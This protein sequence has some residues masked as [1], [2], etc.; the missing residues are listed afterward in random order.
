MRIPRGEFTAEPAPV[1]PVV[2]ALDP[3]GTLP[4][5]ALA[6]VVVPEETARWIR[7]RVLPR[8]AL[9]HQGPH[10]APVWGPECSRCPEA[11]CDACRLGYDG[12]CDGW[13]WPWYPEADILSP[14]G[15]QVP[16]DRP[17]ELLRAD[18][19]RVWLRRP[20]ECGCDP[21]AVRAARAAAVEGEGERRRLVEAPLPGGVAEEW[22]EQGELF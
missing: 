12:Q 4:L 17:W 19:R 2:A 22:G 5:P 18:A 13:S 20:C 15:E 7:D 1:V 14:S 9:R 8:G 11:V 21:V 16:G 3:V 6:R 10:H